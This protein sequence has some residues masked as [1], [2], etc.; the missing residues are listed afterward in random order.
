MVV[1]LHLKSNIQ[2]YLLSNSLSFSSVT[3]Q[4]P[5]RT[6]PPFVTTGYVKRPLVLSNKIPRLK[7]P[8]ASE[9]LY[10]ALAFSVKGNLPNWQFERL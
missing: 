6:F 8:F 3:I 10:S 7:A 5:V 9:Y 1:R 4:G 2:D